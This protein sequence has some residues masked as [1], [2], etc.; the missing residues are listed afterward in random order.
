MKKTLGWIASLL[1]FSFVAAAPAWAAVKVASVEGVTE[2]RLANGLRVLL[3]PD[4]SA[5]NR[6]RARHLPRRLAPRGLRRERHGAPARAPAVQGHRSATPTS[7]RSSTS[8]ARASTAPPRNDR[9]NYFET[10]PATRRQ[11]RLG[12]RPGGRPHGRTRCVRKEDLDSEMTVV[13]NE[14]EM[15]ENSAGS[16]LS[17]ACSA[18]P[19]LAQLRQPDHRLALR[20]RVGADRAACRPSTAPGTSRTTRS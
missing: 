18:S 14:F 12:A 17:S 4:P 7:R 10:L 2:Y 3:V 13:R 8:A 5:S 9:T 1:L 20:H 19:S 16:V 11:P 15:G 6:H